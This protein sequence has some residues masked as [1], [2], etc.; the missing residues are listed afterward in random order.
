MAERIVD[1]YHIHCNDQQLFKSYWQKE[2]LIIT[3]FIAMM[4]S[5]SNEWTEVGKQRIMT[6]K[7]SIRNEKIMVLG[8]Q[9][10]E[11][12]NN[13][14]TGPFVNWELSKSLFTDLNQ[15]KTIILMHDYFAKEMPTYIYDPE[16]NFKKL[17]YYLPELTNQYLM[18]DAN[19][20][21]K[22]NK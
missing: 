1:H 14:M 4:F 18:I 15:Y 7:L 21:K 16:S 3:I 6:Q 20:Y 13:Q 2:L 17:G 5:L 22:I 9:I 8:P 19:T 11:Y 10:E 12:Q